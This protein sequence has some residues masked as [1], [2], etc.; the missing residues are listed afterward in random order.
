MFTF[1]FFESAQVHV[2]LGDQ[3]ARKDGLGLAGK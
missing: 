3:L 2:Y 1:Y